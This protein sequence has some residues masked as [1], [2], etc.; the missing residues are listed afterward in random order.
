MN[1]SQFDILQYGVTLQEMLLLC[2]V[3]S[4][5]LLVVMFIF[6]PTG[7]NVLHG[8]TRSAIVAVWAGYIALGQQASL[9]QLHGFYLIYV[10]AK[11]AVVGLVMAF[12]ASPVFWVAE[13][14]GSYVDDLTGY[15][16]VQMTNP[17]QG[18]ETSLTSTLMSQCAM[19]AFW[20]LGGMTYLLGALFESYRLWPLMSATPVPGEVIE[21]FVM[22]QTDSLMQ[23]IAKLA[24]PAML[25]LLLIDV[26]LG[27][28]SRVAQKLD[29]VSL[30]QPVK[31]AMAVLMLALLTGMFIGQVRDQVA[32]LHVGD[33]IR[34]MVDRK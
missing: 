27:L 22:R 11:E 25:L 31:G 33:Q 14:V 10:C 8:T 21:A 30:A 2:G 34:A 5:R 26:G 24:T 15:N 13:A 20:T 17:S 3:C 6:P 9:P 7:D 4:I 23:S 29:I 28:I 16:N 19:I 12:I 18:R 1:Q 32:L